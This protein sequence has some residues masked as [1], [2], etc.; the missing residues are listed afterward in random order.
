MENSCKHISAQYD[1]VLKT[2]NKNSANFTDLNARVQS[3]SDENVLLKKQISDCRNELTQEKTA[4][5]SDAQYQRTSI[6]VKLCGL[7]LQPG[8]EIQTNTPSNPVTSALV[9]RVCEASTIS[10][11]S[12]NDIDVCHRLGS[13]PRS[14]IIIRFVSKSA[15]TYLNIRG[16]KSKVTTL[17]NIIDELQPTIFCITETHLME[18]EEIEIE[19]YKIFDNNRDQDGGG[20]MIGVQNQL[21]DIV[22]MVEKHKGVEESL[23]IVIDNKQ[24]AIRLGVIYA[25]QE[26]R[27][28][29]ER[30]KEMYQNI[31]EQILIAKEK[32][33]KLLMM[34]DFNCKIG[35]VIEGNTDEVSLSGRLFN[36]MIAKNKLLVLNGWENCKGIWTRE[37]GGS[38]NVLDYIVIDQEDAKAV[39]EMTIDE[40]NEVAP[41]TVENVTSDHHVIMATLNWLV[42]VQQEKQAPRSIIKKEGYQKIREGIK[43]RKLVEIF[44][45]DE[46]VEILYKEFKESIDQLAE[47]SRRK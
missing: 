32:N 29:K 36:K 38:R 44:T 47:V 13:Q 41:T 21:K 40:K 9:Q 27:T 5:N 22:T 30:Y 26:S 15:R 23:W 28:S 19:G 12:A 3:L 43:D 14:P 7:P 8:E 24:V 33:Q 2:A 16:L 20:V 34:G 42:E 18:K 25:P 1:E 31:E 39:M 45:K 11:L 46:P 4:R 6:N 10:L 35:K 37:E 17:H